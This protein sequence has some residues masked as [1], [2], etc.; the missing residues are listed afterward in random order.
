MVT[1]FEI[2]PQDIITKSSESLEKAIWIDVLSPSVEER[3]LI[4]REI[5][6]DL[7]L[8]HE[9]YQIEFSNRFYEENNALFLSVNVITKASPIPE[10]HVVTFVLTKGQLVTLRYSDPNPIQTFAE[11]IETRKCYAQNNFDIFLI[12]LR[13]V[14]GAVADIFELIGEQTDELAISL[15]GSSENVAA[16]EHNKTLNR[17]LREINYLQSLLGKGYQS[18]QSLGL[19]IAFI[20]DAEQLSFE[21]KDLSRFETLNQDIST[22]SRHGEHLTQK[23]NFQLQSALG[24][25]NIEQTQ[26]I[27]IFT[28]L[29]MVF[30]PPTLIASI[31]GMNFHH[32]P[33]LDFVYGYPLALVAMLATALLPYLFFKRKKWI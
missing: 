11:T 28:V 7:P 15:V 24:L 27:K 2:G 23:L 9:M 30:M 4:E 26:I 13:K 12:L 18:L 10:S 17:I 29:A 3:Q 22:L 8:H 6:I 5:K 21:S 31:Y 19:L 20:K 32:M 1:K 16:S 33:E 25:I 14:V